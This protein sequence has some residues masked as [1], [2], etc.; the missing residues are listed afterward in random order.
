MKLLCFEPNTGYLSV[1]FNL[2]RLDESKRFVK[3]LTQYI[4]KDSICEKIRAI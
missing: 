2:N 3:S 4:Q 1:E